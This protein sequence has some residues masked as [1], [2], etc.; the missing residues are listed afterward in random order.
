VKIIQVKKEK[1]DSTKKHYRT[2]HQELLLCKEQINETQSLKKR[3]MNALLMA[4]NDFMKQ[5]PVQSP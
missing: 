4:F 1:L 2:V 5:I 3:A